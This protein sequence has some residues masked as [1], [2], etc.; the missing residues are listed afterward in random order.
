[1]LI[2]TAGNYYFSHF[3]LFQTLK[4]SYNWEFRHSDSAQLF[5]IKVQTLIENQIY[6]KTV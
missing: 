4:N 6:L 3:L 1:M 5:N 2:I